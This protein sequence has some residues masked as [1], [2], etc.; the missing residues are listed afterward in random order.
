MSLGSEVLQS[1]VSG[2]DPECNWAQTP[3]N[4]RDSLAR[5]GESAGTDLVT[6]FAFMLAFDAWIG[7]VDRHQQNWGVIRRGRSIRLAPMFDPAS[8]LGVELLEEH[9]L[10]RGPSEQMLRKYVDNCPSGFG[11][12]TRQL[13][14]RDVVAQVC[15][16]P[17][18]TNNVTRWLAGFEKAANTTKEWL[19]AVPV[20]WLTDARKELANA[21]L[22][23]RLDWLKEA[24]Q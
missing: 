7:N 13:R 11:D 12:G 21:L 22:K 19:A 2:Y 15:D 18:W 4:V 6:P 10:L 14:M 8:C 1:H 9:E 17:E 5:L 23:A 16:W 24:G 3:T 20:E